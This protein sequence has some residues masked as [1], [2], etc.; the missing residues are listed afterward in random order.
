MK[1]GCKTPEEVKAKMSAAKREWYLLIISRRFLENIILKPQKRRC[2]LHVKDGSKK[3]IIQIWED[4]SLKIPKKKSRYLYLRVRRLRWN[5]DIVD[6]D[7]IDS[8]GYQNKC[9]YE[10]RKIWEREHNK[11]IP[12]GFLVHHIDRNKANNQISNLLLISRED[13]PKLHRILRR[14]DGRTKQ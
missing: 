10:H 2:E 8:S 13:H 9:I 11:K 12:N 1:R 4:T 5:M 6:Y 14:A 3:I 7:P